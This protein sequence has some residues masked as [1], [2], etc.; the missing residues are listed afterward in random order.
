MG[1]RAGLL[2]DELAAP[3]PHRALL[4]RWVG[5]AVAGAVRPVPQPVP[6]QPVPHGEPIM[7]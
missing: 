1:S 7:L 3:S 4:H 6:P 2:L 5:V